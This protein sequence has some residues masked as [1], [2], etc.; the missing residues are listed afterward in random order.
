MDVFI[1]SKRNRRGRRFCFC[2]YGRLEE[3]E[4]IV[5]SRWK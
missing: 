5:E 2:R 4:S 3:A 1:A